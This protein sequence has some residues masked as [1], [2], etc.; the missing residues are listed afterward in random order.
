[1]I[2]DAHCHLFPKAVAHDRDSFLDDSSFKLLYQNPKTVIADIIILKDYLENAKTDKAI[3]YGFSWNS[4][5]RCLLHNEYLLQNKTASIIPF[6]SIPSTP[7][8]N[9]KNIIREIAINGFDGV[10]ELSFYTETFT[11]NLWKY[12]ETVFSTCEQEN[13]ILTM[14]LNDPVG[15]DY[16]GK[17]NTPFSR[18]Y[19]LISKHPKL[20][21]ILSHF[22]GGILFY[23]MMPEVKEAFR[24][25]WYDSAAQPYLYMPQIYKN[26]LSII[27]TEKLLFGT[28]YPL[29]KEKSYLT[30]IR[31]QF[32]DNIAIFDQITGTNIISLL[33][34]GKG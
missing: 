27:G 9:I 28:D 2:I 30:A 19:Q 18:L 5:K 26:T 15:H 16:H 25:V 3:V 1:M 32:K 21:I 33:Q 6:A 31:E 17:Y 24:N 34:K 10:G 11:D 4:S 22:G 23:E 13:L 29:L 14:H 8:A 20:R 12:I 7:C